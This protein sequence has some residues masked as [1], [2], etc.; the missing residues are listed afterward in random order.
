[1][2]WHVI[3]GW[4][5]LMIG[6]K[7]GYSI[8]E[9]VIKMNSFSAH[10]SEKYINLFLTEMEVCKTALCHYTHIYLS[11]RRLQIRSIS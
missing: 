5:D 8:H 9:S 7:S 10:S 2:A 6:R 1:M 11:N 4:K 3:Y